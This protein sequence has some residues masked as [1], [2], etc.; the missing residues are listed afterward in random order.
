MAA[1]LNACKHA[2]KPTPASRWHPAKTGRDA[3]LILLL[4]RRL[5]HGDDP[6]TVNDSATVRH[7][8][9]IQFIISHWAQ[10]CLRISTV[11]SNRFNDNLDTVV[12]GDPEC[13]AG[14]CGFE[15]NMYIFFMSIQSRKPTDVKFLC[16]SKRPS[17]C[18]F[19]VA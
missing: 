19:L 15:S 17:L 12:V 4:V 18:S 8:H 16:S 1:A 14:G 9:D 2:E 6:A 10:H 3:V 11:S 5:L 13:E 7:S